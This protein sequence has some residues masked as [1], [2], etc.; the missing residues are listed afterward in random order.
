VTNATAPLI[1]LLNGGA[2]RPHRGDAAL[3]LA[4]RFAQQQL[5]IIGGGGTG[6][7]WT[8]RVLFDDEKGALLQGRRSAAFKRGTVEWA[9][10]LANE[11]QATCGWAILLI[12][13]QWQAAAS[14]SS[15][16]S[17]GGSGVEQMLRVREATSAFGDERLSEDAVRVA[18]DHPTM[19]GSIVGAVRA[20][21][22][23][24]LQQEAKASGFQIAAVRVGV[25]ALLERHLVRLQREGASPSRSLVV[26]DGQS[27]LVIGVRDG[28]FESSEGGVSYLVNRAPSE[29]RTQI[30]RRLGM[31]QMARDGGGKVDWI[32]VPLSSEDAGS[33]PAG[34]EVVFRPEDV[35]TAIVDDDVKHDFRTDLQEMRTALPPWVRMAV[36][37]ALCL[38][39]ACTVGIAALL[40][41]GTRTSARAEEQMRLGSEHRSARDEARGRL[42]KLNHEE[43]EARLLAQWLDKNYHT[44][45][46][47]H[48]FLTVLPAEVSLDAV[49]VH[50]SEGLP[51]GKLSFTLLGSE[52]AQRHA[53]RA[54]ESKLYALGYQ[55]AKRDDP[56]AAQHRRG[57]IVH[58]WNLIFPGL[59]AHST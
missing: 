53:L 24:P 33:L 19:E 45:A 17:L 37:G 51:Q 1:E 25:F 16:A 43:A 10:H 31:A 27:A 12:E 38:T 8:Q 32:G 44:Q 54:I 48:A 42:V 46:L 23:E 14:L 49:S 6:S 2:Y 22:I 36:W 59:G 7:A 11:A 5:T 29:V 50:A 47:L 28:A 56:T 34:V 30:S 18:L 58:T 26:Y 40:L 55:I 52:D 15:A 3:P 9:Q 39:F 4:R 20:V 21:T 57:S 13:Q 41:Q 35:L